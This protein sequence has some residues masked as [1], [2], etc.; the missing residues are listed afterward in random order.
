MA[1][2]ERFASLRSRLSL[3]VLENGMFQKDE[4]GKVVRLMERISAL[5]RRVTRMHYN[6]IDDHHQE[7][8]GELV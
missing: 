5:F 2:R 4:I 8:Q 3:R 7:S 1:I 6:M